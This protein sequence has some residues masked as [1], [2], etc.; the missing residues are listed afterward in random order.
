MRMGLRMISCSVQNMQLCCP[1]QLDKIVRVLVSSR[2]NRLSKAIFVCLNV[3][4][5]VSI[6]GK[7]LVAILLLGFKV[8]VRSQTYP[9]NRPT[10]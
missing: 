10:K 1:Q 7:S 4:I 8:L 6:K 3:I 2:E 5:R 9:P